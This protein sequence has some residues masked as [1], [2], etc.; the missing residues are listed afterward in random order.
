MPASA[1]PVTPP[2]IQQPI[3]ELAAA[4]ACLVARAAGEMKSGRMGGIPNAKERVYA[5]HLFVAARTGCIGQTLR[6]ELSEET[7]VPCSRATGRRQP[8]LLGARAATP[9]RLPQLRARGSCRCR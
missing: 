3:G 6:R 8:R 1:L 5:K 4:A 2:S 7:I 9:A